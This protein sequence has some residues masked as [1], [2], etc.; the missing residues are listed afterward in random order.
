MATRKKSLDPLQE[1]LGYRFKD[2]GLL[3]TA[4]THVSA[5][6]QS[7]AGNY[8][9][10]EFLGDRVLGLAVAETLYRDLSRGRRGR[11]VPTAVGT[12]APR[13]CAQVAAAWDVGPDMRLGAG[14]A[15]AGERR[16]ITILADVCEAIIGAVFLDGGYEEARALV[17]RSFSAMLTAPRHAMRD[18]KS[19]LQEWAQGQGWPAPTYSVAEQIGPGPRAAVP[20]RR[21]GK[22][23][24]RRRSAP[25]HR[26]GTR[27]KRPRAA[28]SSGKAC[29]RRTIMAPA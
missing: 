2:A 17:Q 11:I 27:N 4:L 13:E 23:Q 8:Q 26:N 16:N 28:F 10:L 22:G 3:E 5:P 24:A 9:R 1:R 20:H 21:L 12:G 29:G 14:E 18:P 6:K 7:A 15:H 25:V 19:A